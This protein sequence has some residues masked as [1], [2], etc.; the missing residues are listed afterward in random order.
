MAKK[1]FIETLR[2]IFKPLP[3]GPSS[4]VDRKMDR[5]Q[6]FRA[7]L[8]E[9]LKPLDAAIRPLEHVARE[10]GKLDAIESSS[11][12]ASPRI[13]PRIER[14]WQRPPGALSEI[15]F[16]LQCT[17]CGDCV[18]ACPVYAIRTDHSGDEGGGYPYIDANSQPCTLCEGQPCMPACPTGA[19]RIVPLEQIDM[20]TA[21]WFAQ[22]CRRTNGEECTICVDDCPVGVAAIQLIEGRVVVHIEGCTGCGACQNHCPTDPKSIIVIP[23]AAREPR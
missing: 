12:S 16:R 5:R 23:K 3:G 1:G 18:A 20:G 4:L 7:G 9:M 22:T 14:P 19:L 15:D 13:A 21:E 10:V 2:D 17:R 8:A 11:L 6:F